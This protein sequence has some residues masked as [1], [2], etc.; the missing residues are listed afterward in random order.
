MISLVRTSLLHRS[1]DRG[2]WLSTKFEGK[3]EGI[4]MTGPGINCQGIDLNA[5][6][7]HFISHGYDHVQGMMS[8]KYGLNLDG[9]KNMAAEQLAVMKDAAEKSAWL[10]KNYKLIEDMIGDIIDGQV[11]WSQVQARLVGRGAKGAADIEKATGDMM[12]A[13]LKWQ[14]EIT[15]QGIRFE[16]KE[17]I[18]D[19]K[20]A[21]YRVLTDHKYTTSLQI[22]ADKLAN[23]MAAISAAPNK[24]L[25]MNAWNEGRKAA[26]KR[27][28]DALKFGGAA[29]SLPSGQYP[30]WESQ[31]RAGYAID[32]PSR[33]IGTP[34][35]SLGAGVG[36]AVGGFGQSLKNGFVKIGNWLNPGRVS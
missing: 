25:A 8:E 23:Q 3:F 6:G 31:S 11:T 17:K 29:S 20:I 4:D 18:S 7:N 27:M 32:V 30:A 1:C 14:A 21:N 28:T 19:N 33:S 13:R 24:A 5:L 10:A 2:N 34:Q 22:E 36:E 26:L 15:K 16:G 9:V 12:I 35:R